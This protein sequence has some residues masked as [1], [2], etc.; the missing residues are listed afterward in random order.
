[1]ADN[2]HLHTTVHTFCEFLDGKSVEWYGDTG[3]TV[4]DALQRAIQHALHN[5]IED[6]LQERTAGVSID[7][8]QFLQRNFF[9]TLETASIPEQIGSMIDTHVY[10]AIH[11]ACVSWAQ[12]FKNR[13]IKSREDNSSSPSESHVL[14]LIKD[15]L[16]DCGKAQAPTPIADPRIVEISC[17]VLSCMRHHLM[18]LRDHEERARE[19]AQSLSMKSLS[20]VGGMDSQEGVD[21]GIIT[22]QQWQSAWDQPFCGRALV[23]LE[24]KLQL[25]AHAIKNDPRKEQMSRIIPVV[26]ASGTGKSR[27]SEEYDSNFMLN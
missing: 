1:M 17:E 27:L 20:S 22:L 13:L 12:S 5:G 2:L 15:L 6:A 24:T 14:D 26:Q 16:W 19:V 4:V 10:R 25:N 18:D 11:Y 9:W 3:T 7:E 23:A 21:G 8:F